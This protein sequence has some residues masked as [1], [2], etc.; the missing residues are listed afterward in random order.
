MALLP[1]LTHLQAGNGR[2]TRLLISVGPVTVTGLPYFH[3]LEALPLELLLLEGYS[4]ECRSGGR[5]RID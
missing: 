4:S 3:Y 2:A 1:S 5:E